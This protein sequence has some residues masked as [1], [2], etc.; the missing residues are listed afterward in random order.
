MN[1]VAKIIFNDDV[2]QATV[3]RMVDLINGHFVLQH[4]V[5]VIQVSTEDFES[6][7]QDEPAP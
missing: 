3:D 5:A 7:E 2:D 6:E 1:I 4:V